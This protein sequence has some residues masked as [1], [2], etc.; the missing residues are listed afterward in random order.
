MHLAKHLG[1]LLPAQI[2]KDV[3]AEDVIVFGMNKSNPSLRDLKARDRNLLTSIFKEHNPYLLRYLATRGLTGELAEDLVHQTWER[4]FE[5]LEKFGGRSSLRTFLIGIL[6]NVTREFRREVKRFDQGV[7]VEEYLDQTFTPEGSWR[8]TPD[9]PEL[10]LGASETLNLIG[11]CLETLSTSQHAA[12]VSKEVDFMDTEEICNVLGVSV[13]N[14]RVLIFRAKEKLK[15][16]L[17]RK[18]K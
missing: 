14:L 18:L 15:A 6:I 7:N 3:C 16:C 4:F 13:S 5:N 12:F 11:E 9:N 1:Q 2:G 17:E 10:K 8:V